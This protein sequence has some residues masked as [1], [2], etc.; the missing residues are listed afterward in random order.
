MSLTELSCTDA[1]EKLQEEHKELRI[2]H[3]QLK[4]EADDLRDKMRFFTKVLLLL[5]RTHTVNISDI[6][7]F[8]LLNLWPICVCVLL[9]LCE[10][11]CVY[12][13]IYICVC[14]LFW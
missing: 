14:M 5:C 9:C 3:L 7:Y 13:C 2:K 11:M 8:V 10:C 12:V 4:Q 1:H 6:N